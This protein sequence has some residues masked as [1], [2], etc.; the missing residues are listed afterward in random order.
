[1]MQKSVCVFGWLVILCKFNKHVCKLTC[2]ETNYDMP[3]QTNNQEAPLAYCLELSYWHQWL[4]S[5]SAKVTSIKSQKP[6]WTNSMD[7]IPGLHGSW[8]KKYSSLR[9]LGKRNKNE[10]GGWQQYCKGQSTITTNSHLRSW[11]DCSVEIINAGA[12]RC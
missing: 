6:L 2:K 7:R 1:M 10:F 5:P 4:I 8:K 9:L 3:K 11:N 12:P